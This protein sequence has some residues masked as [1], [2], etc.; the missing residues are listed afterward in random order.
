VPPV[1]G[2]LGDFVTGVVRSGDRLIVSYIPAGR[3]WTVQL[4][5][6]GLFLVVAV[7]ALG[8]AIWLLHR[9]TT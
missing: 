2:H 6:G 4:I 7:A 5:D 8:T 9:R 3:F 1:T